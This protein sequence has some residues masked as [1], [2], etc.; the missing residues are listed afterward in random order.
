MFN[1]SLSQYVPHGP[2]ISDHHYIVLST[3]LYLW[4]SELVRPGNGEV[5]I[6]IDVEAIKLW[7]ISKIYCNSEHGLSMVV[8]SLYMC[9]S[10]NY[11]CN[12]VNLVSDLPQFFSYRL[13]LHYCILSGRN[14]GLCSAVRLIW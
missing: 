2:T 10:V 8:F 13:Y 1:I 3:S 12:Q 4:Y 6:M 9:V 7:L 5:K 14:K 11:N